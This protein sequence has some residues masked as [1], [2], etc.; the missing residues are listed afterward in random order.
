[1]ATAISVQLR[2]SDGSF[3][4]LVN[5][6]VTENTQTEIQTGGTGLAQASGVSVGQA[7]VGKV[8]THASVKVITENANTGC[9]CYAYFQAPNGSVASIVQ[10]GGDHASAVAPLLKPI[11]MS[12]GMSFQARFD[13]QADGATQ[14]ASL[15]L[16]C[17][18]GTCEVLTVAGVD[19]TKTAMVNKDGNTIGQALSGKTVV[20]AYATFSS[21]FGMNDSDDGVSSFYVESADGQL[22]AMWPPARGNISTHLV[23]Y[24]RYPV[25]ID[26]NDTCSVLADVA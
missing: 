25:R 11:R 1:M 20:A 12:T 22:K 18:D 26:Q 4:S 3:G 5:S 17:S 13:A 2:F 7:Y 8:C 15:G 24:I 14:Q 6:S 21:Q 23:P 16:Y 10:G 19:A 9:F